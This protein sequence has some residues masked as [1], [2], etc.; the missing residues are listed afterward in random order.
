MCLGDHGIATVLLRLSLPNLP[1]FADASVDV[2]DQGKV[3]VALLVPWQSGR[4]TTF[5]GKNTTFGCFDYEL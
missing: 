3:C 5:S 4:D 1:V 2:A